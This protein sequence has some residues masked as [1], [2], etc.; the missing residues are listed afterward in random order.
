MVYK[1]DRLVLRIQVTKLNQQKQ[2]IF[3]ST[4]WNIALY[5]EQ[6]FSGKDPLWNPH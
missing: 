6:N 2:H 1:N 3:K 4:E 5:L